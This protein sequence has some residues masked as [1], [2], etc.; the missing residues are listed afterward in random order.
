MVLS[1]FGYVFLM[2]VHRKTAYGYNYIEGPSRRNRPTFIKAF[3]IYCILNVSHKSKELLGPNWLDE[4]G[5]M[6]A[7]NNFRKS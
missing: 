5:F 7:R 1:R 2:R 4:I 6:Y 3:T